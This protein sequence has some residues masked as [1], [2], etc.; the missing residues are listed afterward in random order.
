FSEYHAAGSVSASYMVRRG[1]YKY[2]H[3][4]GFQPELFDLEADPEEVSD[5]AAD[6]AMAG[7]LDQLRATLLAICDPEA[8]DQ[9][10][11]HDQQRLIEAHGGEAAIRSRGGSSY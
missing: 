2:I 4:T 10:A 6:P 11:K 1:R 5:R 9:A 8:T 3:Y 7:I